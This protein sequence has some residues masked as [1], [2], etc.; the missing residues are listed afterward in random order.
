MKIETM[1]LAIFTTILLSIG[2]VLF[3]LSASHI[4]FTFKYLFFGFLSN[5]KLILAILI[6][7]VATAAWVVVLKQLP[8]NKAYP[9]A[10]LAFFIVP[11]FSYIILGEPIATKTI[12]GA[13]FI[14]AGVCIS[15]W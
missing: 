13:F 2:Q 1:L 11:I 5:T 15:N 9:F 8:L 6:Y 12:L 3:K 4:S 7:G 14:F 10:A